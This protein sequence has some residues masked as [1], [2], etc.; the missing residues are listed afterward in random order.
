MPKQMTKDERAAYQRDYRARKKREAE[1]QGLIELRREE[2]KTPVQDMSRGGAVEPLTGVSGSLIDTHAS[3]DMKDW[4]VR[5]R[6]S[7]PFLVAPD[8][9][10][11]ACGHDRHTYHTDGS[12]RMPIAPKRRCGCPAYVPALDTDNP[13]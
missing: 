5:P 13:F 7:L 6:K 8:D 9:D 1:E 11:G 3:S 2:P 4:T 10:C 12:C